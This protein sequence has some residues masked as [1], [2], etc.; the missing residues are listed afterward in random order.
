MIYATLLIA[1][2]TLFAACAWH[3]PRLSLGLLAFA[4]PSYLLRFSVAGVPFTL[5]EVLILAFVL[6]WAVKARPNARELIPNGWTIPMGLLLLA[7]T[8]G[9]AVAP[10]TSPALGVW[11]AYFVEPMVLFVAAAHLFRGDARAKGAALT[12]LGASALLVAAFAIVQ[13]LTSWGLPAP[14][15]VEG[16]VTSIYPYPNAVGLFLGPIVVIAAAKA[17]TH[18]A[19]GWKRNAFWIAVAVLGGAA[20]ALA[21]SEAAMVAVAATLGLAALASKTLR[22]P[23]MAAAALAI[24]VALAVPAVREKLTFSDYS[25]NVRR[26]QWEETIAL[27]KDMPLVGAGLSGYP[28]ALIPYH[29]HPEYEIFQYPHHIVLNVWVELGLLGLIAFAALAVQTL[30][31]FRHSITPRLHDSTTLLAFLALLETTVHGLADA[32]YFKNDLAALTWILLALIASSYAHPR[33]K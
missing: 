16:R 3:R 8:V 1:C 9:V 19:E 32:P 23:A 24:V 4:L 10:D 25:G 20:I 2:A 18:R 11:K 12:G 13:R 14:W 29:T 17:W 28:T 30:K 33:R 27:L 15:D 5:L 7:A 31:T 22:R 6:A 26:S 21:Q